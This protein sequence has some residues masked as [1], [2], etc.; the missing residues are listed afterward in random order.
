MAKDKRLVIGIDF[1]TGSSK[2]VLA[3]LNGKVIATAEK[4]HR[5]SMP[6]PGHVEHDA[7]EVWWADFLA[8]THDL[9]SKA[10]GPVVGITTS[11]IGPCSLFCDAEGKPLSRWRT[12]ESAH[13]EASTSPSRS[14]HHTG[15]LRAGSLEGRALPPLHREDVGHAWVGAL[16]HLVNA[17][18]HG[19]VRR[20]RVLRLRCSSAVNGAGV[21]G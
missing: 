19:V 7:D 3:R 21:A 8:I 17:L 6:K 14:R 12:S 9:L 15:Y 13:H 4:A 10:D 18:A 20:V 5:T 16:H 1:G 11:G 2:G